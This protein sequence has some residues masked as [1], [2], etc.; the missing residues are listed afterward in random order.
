[1]SLKSFHIF[2][3][4]MSTIF[5]LGL[6]SWAVREYRRIDGTQNLVM[7]VLAFVGAAVLVVYG[8]WFLYKLKG[9]ES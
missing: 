6:G 4:V 9:L 1:M 8:R 7:A 3:I 2:F 5:A